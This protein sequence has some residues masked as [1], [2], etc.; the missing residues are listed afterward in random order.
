MANKLTQAEEDVMH[1]IW[2]ISK[3]SAGQIRARLE[4]NG[5]KAKPST[6][7][8]VLRIL[9]DKGFLNYEAYGRTFVY[10]PTI[11]KSEYSSNRL[12]SFI[13]RFFGGS[14]SQLVSFLAK[15]ENFSIKEIEQLLEDPDL[16]QEE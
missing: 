3:G 12:T 11:T 16:K 4:E 2:H 1:A 9:V 15:R 5:I 10:Q 14:P 7:S 6:V 8:T 13:H